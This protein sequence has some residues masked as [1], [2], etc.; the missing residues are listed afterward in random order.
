MSLAHLEEAAEEMCQDL[1]Q[2]QLLSL[3]MLDLTLLI[4]AMHLQEIKELQSFNFEMVF[5]EFNK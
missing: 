5:S 4:A 3:P 2:S 1:E